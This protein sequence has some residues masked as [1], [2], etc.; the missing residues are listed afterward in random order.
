DHETALIH[1]HRAFEICEKLADPFSLLSLEKKMAV[2]M[3]ALKQYEEAVRIYLSIL[4][5]YGSYNNPAGAVTTLE[6]LAKLYFEM[7]ERDKA[8][9]TYRTVASIHKNF[10]HQRHAQEFL[11]MAGKIEDGTI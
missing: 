2:S 10:K 1:F 9:D 8:A 7:G 6:E 3:R 4:D 5:T 11:D